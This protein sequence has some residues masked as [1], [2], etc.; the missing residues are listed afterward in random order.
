MSLNICNYTTACNLKSINE[1]FEFLFQNVCSL[2]NDTD[3]PYELPIAN[4]AVLGGI[5]V[6]DGL[7]IDSE[8]VLSVIPT[9]PT[10]NR[11]AIEDNLGI[12]DR[13]MD[14]EGFT[15]EIFSDTGNIDEYGAI[16][17][18][19]SSVSVTASDGVTRGGFDSIVDGCRIFGQFDTTI[20]ELFVKQDGIQVIQTDPINTYVQTFSAGNGFI[21]L[22]VNG[23]FADPSGEIT[24][25]TLNLTFQE[26]TDNG[27]ISTNGIT[28]DSID[29]ISLLLLNGDSGTAGQILTSQGGALPTWEDLPT[30]G[31]QDFQDVTDNGNTSTNSLT[32]GSSN[33]PVGKLDLYNTSSITSF[34]NSNGFRLINGTLALVGSQIQRS[35]SLN[36]S[37]QVWNPFTAT[38]RSAGFS[39]MN[40]PVVTGSALVSA[41]PFS[42]LVFASDNTG[43]AINTL[44]LG[45][46]GT[47]TTGNGVIF[48]YGDSRIT[49]GSTMRYVGNSTSLKHEFFS[50]TGALAAA[51][52]HMWIYQGSSTSGAGAMSLDVW[53]DGN[54][55]LLTAFTNGTTRLGTGAPNQFA[56]LDMISTG[57]GLLLPRMDDLQRDGIPQGI[58]TIPVSAGGS[59]YV[60][61]PTVVIP[62][63]VGGGLQARAHAVLTG[64]AVTSIVVDFRGSNY[65]VAPTITL[66][67]TGTGGLGP[68]GSGATIGTVTVDVLTIP[69]GLMIFNTDEDGGNGGIQFYNGGGIWKTL[70]T[71]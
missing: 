66:N 59:G 48:S 4:D 11:F 23:N 25:P 67:N 68:D 56:Q 43:A 2:L 37:S 14:M 30:I 53:G 70:A 65:T 39:V 57:R 34:S 46:D 54:I 12:Q 49:S 45:S 60:T 51:G 6:G 41:N 62:T 8:G 61:P 3:E 5:K 47:V 42:N 40:I 7:T 21:P 13:Q 28:V 38:S 55:P 50:T 18:D 63:P 58:A 71:V 32:I 22:S 17:L 27:S 36:F 19:D 31:T 15:F 33:A 35:P 10:G 20:K 9:F 29:I 26:V 1:R 24:I 16:F 44:T 69:T 64:D 52:R